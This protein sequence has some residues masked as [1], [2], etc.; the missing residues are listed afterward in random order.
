MK[1]L[2]MYG[3]LGVFKCISLKTVRVFIPVC[4]SR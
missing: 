4:C 2:I 3:V 1:V